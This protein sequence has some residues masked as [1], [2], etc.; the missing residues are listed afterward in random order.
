MYAGGA[1]YRTT[2]V[3]CFMLMETES[4]YSFN[5]SLNVFVQRM[6]CSCASKIK[7]FSAAPPVGGMAKAHISKYNFL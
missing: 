7:T 6:G 5:K 4:V 2:V 1:K 3:A